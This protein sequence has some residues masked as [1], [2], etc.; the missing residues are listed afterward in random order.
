V[1][2]GVTGFAVGDRV[3]G[4]FMP[5]GR[6][7]NAEYGVLPA[8]SVATLPAKLTFEQGAALVKAGLTGRQT[9]EALEVNAGDRV[10]VS[11]ALG[12]VG[13]A[14]VQYL[15]QIG[16]HPV[17]G[18]RAKRLDEARALVGDA[19]DLESLVSQPEFD[20]AISTA[21]S[22]AVNLFAHVRD[23]GRVASIVPVPQGANRGGRLTIHELIHRTDSAMLSAVLDAAAR[24]DLVVPIAQTLRLADI[25]AAHEAVAAGARGKVV[26]KH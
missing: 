12:C 16:A 14:A 5:N 7:S 13:R 2:T 8:T 15:K 20:Y 11:G 4:D 23:G 21:G 3:V 18:V 17:P 19:L 25:G 26:L 1:L 10:L 6:G 22:A 9:V 24:G